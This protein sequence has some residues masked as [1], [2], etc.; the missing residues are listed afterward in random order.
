MKTTLF[1]E[2]VWTSLQGGIKPSSGK[3]RIAPCRVEAGKIILSHNL[4]F[5]D[6]C[7]QA[8][9][10]QLFI[11][12]LAEVG[13]F[14]LYVDPSDVTWV[15]VNLGDT[16]KQTH[17]TLLKTFSTL[18]RFLLKKSKSQWFLDAF[19]LGCE[20]DLC[21]ESALEG[22]LLSQYPV[23][24]M[25]TGAGAEHVKCIE[26]FYSRKQ[27][28]DR[29][30]SAS[31]GVHLARAMINTNAD[32]MTPIQMATIA[33]DL[34]KRYA[35]EGVECHILDETEI[36]KE[37]MGLLLAVTRASRTPPR[38]IVLKYTPKQ[39]TGSAAPI[40]WIG[41]GVSY[42]TGGLSIKPADS[43]KTQRADM[44]GAATVLGAFEAAVRLKTPH[45]LIAVLVCAENAIGSDSYKLGDTYVSRSG[46]TI[47]VVNTDAEGRLVLADAFDY[48]QEKFSPQIMI[49]LAT[50]TGA[51]IVA[52]GHEAAA[53]LSPDETLSSQLIEAGKRSSERLWPL[54]LY[55]E[56]KEYL[57]SDVADMKNSGPRVASTCVAGVFLKQFVR[58]GV[59]WAHLDIAGVAFAE[60]ERFHFSKLATGF[61]V[62][63]LLN[64]LFA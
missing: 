36:A 35:N 27:S 49:D 60:K 26:C 57:S 11:S 32:Q 4:S 13:G 59:S 15:L 48:V 45:S 8:L 16:S 63:T 28:W 37:R 19:P 34:A 61:G 38:L 64:W 42:D 30:E 39:K 24:H 41:K 2:P 21:I 55:D 10:R 9:E 53:V 5:Q 44:S 31:Y 20:T 17:E 51:A 46:K 47:E 40:A 7:L 14:A 56:Y 23:S 54:P 50:L 18:G 62:R 29:L 22:L 25:A 52:L 1:Q 6:S 12:S 33:C 43:M 58:P 3:I